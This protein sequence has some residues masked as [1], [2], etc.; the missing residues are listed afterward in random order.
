MS[1]IWS[2]KEG[3]NTIHRSS[4]QYT[5]SSG[6]VANTWNMLAANLVL[7]H[8]ALTGQRP[9]SASENYGSLCVHHWLRRIA[10]RRTVR[11]LLTTHD[12]LHSASQRMAC[13]PLI[14]C[15]FD[16]L[17]QKAI[18]LY[19]PKNPLL[20]DRMAPNPSFSYL[21]IYFLFFFS[22]IFGQFGISLNFLL[23]DFTSCHKTPKRDAIIFNQRDCTCVLSQLSGDLLCHI[24]T[25]W[26]M[27]KSN[28]N[29][30]IVTL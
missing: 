1:D 30:G 13:Y 2:T 8:D 3:G 19:K 12:S 21:F 6:T 29:N 23:L 22:P 17:F 9:P 26:N 10:S 7:F 5:A 18:E 16:S 15:F 25:K 20:S 4:F 24:F 27:L 11:D 14:D 28:D